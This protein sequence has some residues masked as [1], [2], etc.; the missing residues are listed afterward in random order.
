MTVFTIGYEGYNV[1]DFFNDL[2]V[3]RVET[4][5]DIRELPLSHKP[6]FSKTSLAAT[7]FSYNLSYVHLTA[8]GCPR[9]IRHDYR[10]DKDW[11]K[12]TR[13]FK[14]YLQTQT[15]E[16]EA[17]ANRVQREQCCL[18]CAEADH[19][20]CHRRYVADALVD[21]LG[22]DLVIKHLE[23]TEKAQVF[24]LIPLADKSLR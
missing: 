8:L 21:Y 17:L 2:M 20:Y 24:W 11:A 14:T 3:N 6:G 10:K 9:E 15:A 4:I 5:V 1:N 23:R 12:Y 22:N 16:I 19:F 18:L 13:R 7:A